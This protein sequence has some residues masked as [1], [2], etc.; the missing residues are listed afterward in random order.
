[1]STQMHSGKIG[2]KRH[3]PSKKDTDNSPETI[4]RNSI[5]EQLMLT[6]S[7]VPVLTNR[8]VAA[9]RKDMIEISNTHNVEET[10]NKYEEYLRG[11]TDINDTSTMR[12]K[13]PGVEFS[14]MMVIKQK[15]YYHREMSKELAQRK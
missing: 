13:T 15:T 6:G 14:D 7:V 9:T 8:L 12:A 11:N 1:M 2:Q 4:M 10:S 5:P 3:S